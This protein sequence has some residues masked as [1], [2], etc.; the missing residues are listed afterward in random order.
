MGRATKGN[1]YSNHPFSGA[2][3]VSGRVRC[4]PKNAVV[5]FCDNF[6]PN[7]QDVFGMLA[8]IQQ[9][10]LGMTQH[11]R[12]TLEKT[13]KISSFKVDRV[14]VQQ[15]GSRTQAAS[16]FQRA[17]FPFQASVW[18]RRGR[19]RRRRRSMDSLRFTKLVYKRWWNDEILC[20][21]IFEY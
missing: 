18:R 8:N 15:K 16:R 11:S 13:W 7:I 10:K 21:S 1:D 14:R 20:I 12:T 6:F 2:M 5:C 4:L 19:R 17:A 9:K 3:L